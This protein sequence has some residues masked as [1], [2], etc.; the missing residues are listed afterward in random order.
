M[1]I[2][3]TAVALFMFAFLAIGLY[4]GARIRKKETVHGDLQLVGTG[5]VFKGSGDAS[6]CL[7]IGSFADLGDGCSEAIGGIIVGILLLIVLIIGIWVFIN[8]GLIVIF[9]LSIA[10]GWIFHR[11]IRQVFSKSRR[12]RGD[13]VNSLYFA[14]IYTILYTGWLFI[15]LYAADYLMKKHKPPTVVSAVTWA[16]RP[17]LSS[18]NSGAWAGRPCYENLKAELP[19]AS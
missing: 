14:A 19:A 6:G 12:C 15:I 13:L 11:A 9:L 1:E 18:A 10:V 2:T 5:G 3:L 4:Y 8:V 17:C 7:D 16:S